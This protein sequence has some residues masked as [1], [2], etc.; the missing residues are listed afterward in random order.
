MHDSLTGLPG[1]RLLQERFDLAASLS[2]R[3]GTQMAVLFIDLDGFKAVNDGLG[4]AA[5]DQLLIQV[6]RRMQEKLRSTDT[7][8]RIGGDEFAVLLT[9]LK[10]R[11]ALQKVVSQLLET[12]AEPI[13]IDGRES[14]VS[15]SIGVAMHP[16]DGGTGS[17]N[18]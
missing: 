2:R 5:G 12:I 13:L 3:E 16:A 11:A 18:L 14:R 4:H 7:V 15:G 8:A 9:Q 17:I 10:E 6:A 1:M